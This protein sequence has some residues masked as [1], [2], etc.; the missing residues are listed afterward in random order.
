MPNFLRAEARTIAIQARVDL[1]RVAVA[2]EQG[3][4]AGGAYPAELTGLAP[5]AIGSLPMDLTDGQP[6]RYRRAPDGAFVLYSLS[7]NRV[8]DGGSA[9]HDP[10]APAIG[11]FAQTM[12]WTWSSRPPEKKLAMQPAPSAR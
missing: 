7:Y 12:D 6:L 8:D 10:T 5:A 1:A 4:L 2:L 9:E 3:R 11:S